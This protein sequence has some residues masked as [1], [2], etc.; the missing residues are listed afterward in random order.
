MN[1]DTAILN[2]VEAIQKAFPT[3]FWTATSF[4]DEDE[5]AVGLVRKSKLVYI[6]NSDFSALPADDMRYYAEFEHIDM[7]SLEKRP[8]KTF[9]RITKE[10]LINEMRE[11]KFE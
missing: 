3:D 4:W 11:I 10:Q 5:H 6:S 1:K 9:E 2:I 8:E 7:E